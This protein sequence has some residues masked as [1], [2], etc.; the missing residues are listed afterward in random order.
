MLSSF[1][2]PRLKTIFSLV[3]VIILLHISQSVISLKLAENKEKILSFLSEKLGYKLSLDDI[4]FRFI[5]GLRLKGMII[6]SRKLEKPPVFIKEARVTF[7][8]LPLFIG[9]IGLGKIHVNE[10]VFLMKREEEGINLQV[11]FSNIYKRLIQRKLL[12]TQILIENIDVTID[13]ARI[14][15]AGDPKLNKNPELSLA[16]SHIQQRKNKLKFKGDIKF[17][18]LLPDNLFISRFFKDKLL[19]QNIRCTLQGNI[20]GKNMILDM[21]QL[22]L[23]KEQLLGIGV[24]RDFMEKNPFID[25]IFIPSSISLNNIPFIK[26]NFNI[27]G[28]ASINFK[29]NGLMDNPDLS[30]N[31]MVQNCAFR[32]HISNGEIFDVQ[33]LYGELEYAGKNF[34]LNNIDLTLNNTPIQLDMKIDNRS[35]Q[36]AVNFNFSLPEQFLRKH[37]PAFKKL[38]LFFSGILNKTL[39]GD[40]KIKA[41]YMRKGMFVNMEGDFKDIDF[42]YFDPAGKTFK[43]RVFKLAKYNSE[44][45]QQLNLKDLDSSI[46]VGKNRLEIKD[47]KFSGYSGKFNASLNLDTQGRA[48]IKTMIL[49]KNLDVKKL[50]PEI[51]VTDKLLTGTMETSII[52]NNQEQEFLSGECLV[53]NGTMDLS[54]LSSVVKLPPLKN[55]AFKTMR[56]DFAITPELIRMR[57]LK[58]EN[59]DMVINASWDANSKLTGSIDIQIKWDL[60]NQS[61]P[62]RKLLSLIRIKG[63]FVDFKFLLGGTPKAVRYMWLKN[64]FKE[65][66]KE[67]LPGWVKRSIEN[68]LDKTI[69]ELSTQ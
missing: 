41:L 42:D 69:D 30:V 40:L 16:D 23:G 26:N 19:E 36:P 5:E 8:V 10:A 57:N 32:Y 64:E 60:L 38:E 55:K 58:I 68:S 48:N 12:L 43:A 39:K 14:I 27:T 37:D 59:H 53:K 63:P 62:F 25:I 18:Y 65:R 6:Y 66:L 21:V 4:S 7:K 20:L 33:N 1:L 49:G 35:P 34:K 45:V 22:N 54:A 52:L 47:I 50:M 46:Y 56:A 44:K 29:I 9:K 61:A 2:K 3:I 31:A 24:T 13:K 28:S 17:K 51:N 11:V 15:L 67:Q